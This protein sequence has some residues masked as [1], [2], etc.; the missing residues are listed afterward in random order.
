MLA[1]CT[2]CHGRGREGAQ[3][4]KAPDKV[5]FDDPASI[6]M[7]EERIWNRAGD[8]NVTMPPVGGPD[9]ADRAL[10]GEWLACGSPMRR[11]LVP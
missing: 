7:F 3:R 11:D 9:A 4:S 1:H 2:G 5:T 10:F 6:R 8:H